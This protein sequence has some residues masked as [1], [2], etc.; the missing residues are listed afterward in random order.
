MKFIKILAS[1]MLAGTVALCANPVN[2]QTRKATTVK[3]SSTG[4]AT[5]KS[6]SKSATGATVSLADS[7]Y[8]GI[9]KIAGQPMDLYI[10][11]KLTSAT[12][13]SLN[14]G[15]MGEMP[16]TY[17]ATKSGG[18]MSVKLSNK[19]I[20][21]SLTSKDKGSSL[22]GTLSLP[23]AKA[24]V[25]LVKVNETHTAPT[26]SDEELTTIVGSP[27]GYTAFVIGEQKGQKVCFTADCVLKGT[28]NTWAVTFDNATAQN[29]FGNMQGTYSIENGKLL[30]EDSAGKTSTADIYDDGTYIIFPLGSGNGFTFNMV[31]VR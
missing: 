22:E 23:S 16:I 19:A 28:D 26:V 14:M 30:A 27:D 3:S 4:T 25:W 5:K 10:S 2:A 31:L 7:Y 13:G 8:E 18:K 20:S 21:S 12:E 6:V 1:M 24:E 17:S 9:M 29:I 15:G 11:V